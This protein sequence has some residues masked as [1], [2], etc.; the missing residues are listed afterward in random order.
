VP[1][2]SSSVTVSLVPNVLRISKGPVTYAL[3]ITGQGPVDGAQFFTQAEDEMQ[4]GVMERKAGYIVKPHT[5]PRS[6][7]TIQGSSEFLYI[8]KGRIRATVFDEEWKELGKEEL[9]AGDFLL[10]L[11]GGHSVEIL[12]DCRM[13][14]VKQGP[15]VGEGAK[16]FQ[17]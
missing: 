13:I 1:Y 16:A 15:Y 2:E 14:E 11:R 12:E 7:R 8:E 4:A 6:E 3:F 5:H 10:F 17:E 9:K